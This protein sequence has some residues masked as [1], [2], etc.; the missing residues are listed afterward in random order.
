MMYPM[1]AL[2][3]IG[4]SPIV[5]FVIIA[6][7]IAFALYFIPTVIPMDAKAWQIIRVVVLIALILWGLSLWG[8]I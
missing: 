2:L 6:V 4:H 8:I 7:L 5:T 1:L 3:A